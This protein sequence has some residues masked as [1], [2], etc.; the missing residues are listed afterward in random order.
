MC[1]GFRLRERDDYFWVDFDHFWSEH[2]FAR[3]LG[4]YWKSAGAYE[5]QIVTKLSLPKSLIRH[6]YLSVILWIIDVWQSFH[7]SEVTLAGPQDEDMNIRYC[8]LMFCIF[9][10]LIGTLLWTVELS[11]YHRF[12]ILSC[13][14]R[15]L[16]INK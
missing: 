15:R 2:H 12:V 6:P 7:I 13:V 4:Q 11:F 3:Q 1:H 9:C 10:T 8:D 14:L 5:L 16:W